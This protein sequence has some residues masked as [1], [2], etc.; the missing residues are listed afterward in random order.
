MFLGI[1]SIVVFFES[2]DI[3]YM[4]NLGLMKGYLLVGKELIVV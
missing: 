2:K 3:D 1:L 4:S